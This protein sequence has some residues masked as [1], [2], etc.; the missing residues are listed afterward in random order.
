M[1]GTGIAVAI[2]AAAAGAALTL[3]VRTGWLQ[4]RTLEKCIGLSVV[5]HLILAIVAAFLGGWSP[6]SWGRREE[7]RM[8]ML[9]VLADEEIDDA[10]VADAASAIGNP[11]DAPLQPPAGDALAHEDPPPPAALTPAEPP[12]A[13]PDLVPLLDA[14]TEKPATTMASDA[15]PDMPAPAQT[16]GSP[17]AGDPAERVAGR[18]PDTYADRIGSRRAAAAAARGGSEA[19]ERAVRAA[20][21]WLARNQSSDGRWNAARHGAGRGRPGASQHAAD[22]GARAD[23]GVTG[24][25]LLAL[26]GAGNTHREG[27]H[28]ATVARGLGFLVERQRADGSLAGDAAFFTS[29][30]CHGMATIAVAEAAAMSGD[31][32][33][34]PVLERATRYT[35]AMQHPIT[36]GWRYT[37]GD[38]GD[39]SQLGWQVMALA[40]ARNA[41][42]TGFDAAEARAGSFL[43]GVSSGT[44][45]G[46]VSYRTGERPSVAMTAEALFCRLL[47]GMPA[48]HPAAVEATAVLAGA[49]PS[50]DGYNVY[51]WYYGTLASFHAGGPQ[52]D[53]W[54]NRLQAALL[55]LQHR[56][57]GQLDGSWDPD[58]VWGRH[59]GRVY[60]TALA[61]LTLEVY[62]RYLPMHDRPARMAAAP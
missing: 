20:L 18:M 52:W 29:L 46:L 5:L 43:T 60:A 21:A 31:A 17:A 53:I 15:S 57:G 37:A 22:V 61:A 6:A 1:S 2:L 32:S 45:G 30:Y 27:P 25:A 26:L 44:A 11:E 38:R 3:L 16:S 10:A 33:L 54:N 59:G 58:D 51:T 40:A 28:A 47:M 9:V 7:G 62:Y 19:T 14:P 24:L 55:P 4:S 39:T 42:L 34:K 13:P 50:R 56:G 48:D 49:A 35:L 36:G 41:G 12:H 8:T 23:H